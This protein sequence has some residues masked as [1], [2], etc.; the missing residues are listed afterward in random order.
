MDKIKKNSIKVFSEIESRHS[1]PFSIQPR[2][3]LNRRD[4]LNRVPRL[5]VIG[6]AVNV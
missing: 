3:L 6:E 2:S 4:P 5:D 1:M